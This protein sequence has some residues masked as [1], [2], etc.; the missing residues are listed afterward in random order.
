MPLIPLTFKITDSA[1]TG[2]TKR[3][4]GVAA[5]ETLRDSGEYWHQEIMPLH[6]LPAVQRRYQLE[7]RSRAYLRVKRDEGEGQGR[8]AL[9]QRTGQSF[10]FAR[11][12]SRITAT[13]RQ[14]VVRINVPAYFANPR[15]GVVNENGRRFVIRRQPKMTAELTATI[16]ADI[17]VLDERAAE[18][19]ARHYGPSAPKVTRQ[20][21]IQG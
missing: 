1:T 13:Q 2:M 20:K 5:K 17:R 8:F 6:F 3:Q 14:A 21:T 16:R 4:Q 11:F 10:R 18:Q 9:L 12:F 15:T 7:P 19:Y